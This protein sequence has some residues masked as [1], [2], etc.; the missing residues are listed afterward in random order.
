MSLYLSM[1]REANCF[2]LEVRWQKLIE[3][4]LLLIHQEVSMQSATKS[5]R[6]RLPYKWI[7]VIVV[8]FGSFMSVLDQTVINNALPSLQQAFHIDLNHLQ[9]VVTAYTLLRE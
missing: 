5:K 2:A 4:M 6:S 9:W 3:E 7:V 8:M 1:E